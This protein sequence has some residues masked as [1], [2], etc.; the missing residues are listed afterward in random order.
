M[1]K[2]TLSYDFEE[3]Y[4]GTYRLEDDILWLNYN[5]TE[6]PMLLVNDC[7][8]FDIIEKVE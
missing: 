1:N 2:P 5:N 4:E 6:Y 3:T 7:L 8:Y